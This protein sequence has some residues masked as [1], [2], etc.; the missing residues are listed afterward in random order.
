MG[1]HPVAVLASTLG[2]FLVLSLGL[3]VGAAATKKGSK[4]RSRLVIAS[5]AFL[6]YA[7]SLG[8]SL[9]NKWVYET[10]KFPLT[11]TAVHVAMKFLMSAAVLG[12]PCVRRA[13]GPLTSASRHDLLWLVAPIGVATALDIALTNYA[14][15][16]LHL[17]LVTIGVWR[18]RG[19]AGRWG[20]RGRA[21]GSHPYDSPGFPS[22]HPPT[23]PPFHPPTPTPAPLL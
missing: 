4:A 6:F 1:G 22:T 20:R 15:L 23:H 18:W 7:T 10:F 12:C 5:L 17:T 13:P 2:V 11:A 8:M 9:T 3:A 19:R 14:V 16:N 21:P